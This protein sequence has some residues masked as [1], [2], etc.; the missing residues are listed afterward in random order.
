MN[1]RIRMRK[2]FIDQYKNM[3]RY[4]KYLLED[5]YINCCNQLMIELDRVSTHP[6]PKEYLNYINQIN[7]SKRVKYTKK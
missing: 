1:A 6:Y 4:W 2:D 7:T 3:N 5:M